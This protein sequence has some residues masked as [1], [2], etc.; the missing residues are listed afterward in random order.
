MSL[1][2]VAEPL[3]EPIS[4]DE[5]RAHLRVDGDEDYGYIGGLIAAAR[6]HVED[7]LRRTLMPTEWQLQLDD[8]PGRT[9]ETLLSPLT[10]IAGVNSQSAYMP[11]QVASAMDR[12]PGRLLEL[13]MAP[14]RSVTSVKYVDANG[15]EATF[16]STNYTVDAW[17]APGRIA[18]NRMAVWP[19]VQL[20]PVGGVRVRFVAGYADLLT[21]ASPQTDITAARNAVPERY[22]AAIKL[23]VGHL[24]ENR[25]EVMVGAGIVASQLPLGVHKLLM[26]TRVFGF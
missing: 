12:M 7:E 13:P 6:A 26:P 4:V 22:K 10:V 19:G 21:A 3:Y 9:T 23:I 16:A 14:L 25:E 20:L 15:V 17:S 18:L 24:Y 11:L 5:A 1:Q 8:W 2:R